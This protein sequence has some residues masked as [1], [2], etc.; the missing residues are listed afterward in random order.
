M[1]T[2]QSQSP[3]NLF[4]SVIVFPLLREKTRENILEIQRKI[5]FEIFSIFPLIVKNDLYSYYK[6][7]IWKSMESES[8][9]SNF[10]TSYNEQWIINIRINIYFQMLNS[11]LYY[12]LK[13][14]S[15]RCRTIRW[16]YWVI[17]TI[18]FTSIVLSIL[19]TIDL[20]V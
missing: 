1:K 10:N 6:V 11:S 5:V 15:V 2:F 12:S 16:L 14:F 20:N 3:I 8:K 19:N 18:T 4:I 9:N 17:F 13:F 7:S